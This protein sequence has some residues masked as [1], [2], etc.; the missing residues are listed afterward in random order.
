MKLTNFNSK[1]K[2]PHAGNRGLNARQAEVL[3]SAFVLLLSFCGSLNICTSN[4]ALRQAP[5]RCPAT[6]PMKSTSFS[7]WSNSRPFLRQCVATAALDQIFPAQVLLYLPE[8]LRTTSRLT[9][10]WL[11][12]K[13]FRS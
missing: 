4:P 2:M 12:K 9:E 13:C 3:N 6:L 8:G 10:I 11:R 5:N 1:L 7:R